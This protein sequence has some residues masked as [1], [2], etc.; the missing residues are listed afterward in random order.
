[1]KFSDKLMKQIP[2]TSY[3]T[4]ENA[5][6]YRVI[7]RS[8]FHRYERIQYWLYTNEIMQE[9]KEDVRF[10]DYT[11]EECK[12][13]LQVLETWGNVI[14]MQDTT[15]VKTLDEYKNRNFRY[16]LTEYTVEIERMTI[17]LEN[18]S[19][20][21]ASLEPSLLEKIKQSFVE[22]PELLTKK[23]RDNEELMSWWNTLNDQFI[24]L[25]Q[26]YQDYI[27]TLNS[28]SSEELMKTTDFLIYKDAIIDYLRKFVRSLQV[29]SAAIERQMTTI[30][31]SQRQELFERIVSYELWIMK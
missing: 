26:N 11:L 5:Y 24:R 27:L 19:L 18:L 7:I 14:A 13:D 10:A 9:L 30:Q 15:H 20:D 21:G 1:M 2:E 3:L 22:L 31:E 8:M 29:N 16:Q 17:R 4:A 25:N 6:R 28:S 23:N 12:R